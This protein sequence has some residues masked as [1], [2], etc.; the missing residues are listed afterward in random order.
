LSFGFCEQWRWVTLWSQRLR[1][2]A[3]GYSGLKA[4]AAARRVGRYVVSM[5]EPMRRSLRSGAQQI[6]T[7]EGRRRQELRM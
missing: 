5:G 4:V 1:P 3:H 2:I 6:A 7:V